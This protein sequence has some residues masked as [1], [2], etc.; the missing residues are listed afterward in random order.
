MEV[1]GYI[2]GGLNLHHYYYVSPDIKSI[3]D[4]ECVEIIFQE[5]LAMIAN[6]NWCESKNFCKNRKNFLLMKQMKIKFIKSLEHHRQIIFDKSQNK[7]I[8]YDLNE[9]KKF[10]NSRKNIGVKKNIT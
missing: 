7:Y 2:V 4:S 1:R 8:S 6:R 10:Y 5:K 9:I 3:F